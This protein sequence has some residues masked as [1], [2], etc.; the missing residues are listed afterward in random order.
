MPDSN[1]RQGSTRAR[2]VGFRAVTVAPTADDVQPVAHETRDRF[3]TGT[4]TVLPFVGLGIVCWQVWNEALRWSDVVV[5]LI[6]YV[7]TALGVTVGFHRLFTH[8]AFKAKQ[9]VRGALAIFGS[10][11]IE[12]P[13]ISWVAAHRKHDAFSDREGD[14]HSR[15]AAHANGRKAAS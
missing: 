10:A 12:G 5:F 3:I 1:V 11:A 13:I 2:H 8:R 9:S 15:H 4:V 6:C 7:V 14:P